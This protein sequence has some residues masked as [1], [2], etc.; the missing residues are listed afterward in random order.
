M[1]LEIGPELL[2][3]VDGSMDVADA[4]HDFVILAWF[5]LLII[6]LIC[7]MRFFLLGLLG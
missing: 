5:V 2:E 7:E 3:L 1:G 6:H 4:A